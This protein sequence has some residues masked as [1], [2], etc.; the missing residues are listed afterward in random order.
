MFKKNDTLFSNIPKIYIFFYFSEIFSD[1]YIFQSLYPSKYIYTH[2][3]Y[4]TNNDVMY[5]FIYIFGH[6][7]RYVFLIIVLMQ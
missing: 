5:I 3:N 1:L 7:Y 6:S 4:C 2:L